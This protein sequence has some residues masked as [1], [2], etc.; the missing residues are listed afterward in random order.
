[1]DYTT[2]SYKPM[3]SFPFTGRPVTSPQG[4]TINLAMSWPPLSYAQEYQLSLA[5]HLPATRPFF[6]PNSAQPTQLGANSYGP[7]TA[8]DQAIRYTARKQASRPSF[9]TKVAGGRFRGASSMRNPNR[10][11]AQAVLP[12]ATRVLTT[13]ARNPAAMVALTNLLAEVYRKR[14]TGDG[15]ALLSHMNTEL[16]M[17]SSIPDGH[18]LSNYASLSP[19]DRAEVDRIIEERA[20]SVIRAR[21][22]GVTPHDIEADV[23]A[24]Y[25]DEPLMVDPRMEQALMSMNAYKEGVY[26]DNAIGSAVKE[27]VTKVAVKKIGA[28]I[29]SAVGGTVGK[30]IGAAIPFALPVLAIAKIFSSRKKKKKAKAAQAAR[31]A[32]VDRLTALLAPFDKGESIS[33][34]E[35]RELVEISAALGV[36]P[37]L[38]ESLPWVKGMT[39]P[40]SPKEYEA[41]VAKAEAWKPTVSIPFKGLGRTRMVTRPNKVPKPAVGPPG[42]ETFYAG[43]YTA[44]GLVKPVAPAQIVAPPPPIVSAP[45]PLPPPAPRETNAFIAP[46]GQPYSVTSEPSHSAQVVA[47]E[48]MEGFN[49]QASQPQMTEGWFNLGNGAIAASQ[50]YAPVLSYQPFYGYMGYDTASSTAERRNCHMQDGSPFLKQGDG[51]VVEF[52]RSNMFKATLKPLRAGLY[53]QINLSM[54]P[55]NVEINSNVVDSRAQLSLIH[56]CMHGLNELLK[57]G[58]NHEQLHLF[59]GYLMTEVLPAFRALEKQQQS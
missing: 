17:D 2:R 16:R 40:R 54:M 59:S 37:T 42:D 43:R 45:V 35:L 55:F 41:E 23:W 19:E 4:A 13:I 11:F 47:N 22:C 27:Q 9:R 21:L 57:L 49:Q 29:A 34:Y 24:N 53:G 28:G 12:V 58:M 50:Y 39:F 36:R 51:R 18:Y 8:L 46:S 7:P 44:T 1:M 25:Y 32:Q 5:N 15:T 6:W 30:A 52:Y 38:E 48:V 31:Q 14:A 56:E 20:A 26:S 3:T 33:A 10:Y